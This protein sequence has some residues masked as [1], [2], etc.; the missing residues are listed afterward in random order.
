MWLD[1]HRGS[2]YGIRLI[3]QSNYTFGA[4]FRLVSNASG[5]REDC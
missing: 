4:R 2:L 3:F 1:P 5:A